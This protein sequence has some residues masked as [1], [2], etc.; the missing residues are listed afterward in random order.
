MVCPF[1]LFYLISLL[2]EYTKSHHAGVAPNELFTKL[3]AIPISAYTDA[4]KEYEEDSNTDSEGDWPHQ[5]DIVR[6]G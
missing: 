1:K 6:M 4:L 5:D 2:I 3:N